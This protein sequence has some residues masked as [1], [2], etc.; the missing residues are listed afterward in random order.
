MC[1]QRYDLKVSNYNLK[2]G[3][4]A[5]FD[6]MLQN[7][8]YLRSTAKK[9]VFGNFCN[10][11]KLTFVNFKPLPNMDRV[12]QLLI[13]LSENPRDSFLQYALALEYIKKGEMET[14]LKYFEA[15]VEADPDYVGTYYHLGKLYNKLG[16]KSDA[17][18]CYTTGLK[19]ATKL[20][21]QHSFAELQNAKTNLSLGIDDDE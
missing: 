18:N 6:H 8:I 11:S 1:A 14:G 15:L 20:N 7:K 13:Y 4:I 3:S 9:R 19:I 16:R 12:E 17:E 10:L 5:H 21:D 2:R